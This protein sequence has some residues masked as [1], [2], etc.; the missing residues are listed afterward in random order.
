MPDC[1]KTAIVLVAASEDLL[2]NLTVALADT[3]LA[4]LH[5]QSKRETVAILDRLSPEVDLAIIELELP[6][7]EAWDLIR[8]LTFLPKK[9]VKIIATTSTYP[10]HHFARIKGLGVDAV[11]PAAIPPEVWRTTVEAVLG[12]G[13]NASAQPFADQAGARLKVR[14]AG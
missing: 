8:K 4:L 14:N 7:F 3:N 2:S 11:V 5:T 13:E 1:E 12:K 10:E 6:D 9:P